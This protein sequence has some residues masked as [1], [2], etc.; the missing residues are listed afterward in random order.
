[1]SCQLDD[2]EIDRETLAD[3]ACFTELSETKL[4]VFHHY[5]P[6]NAAKATE[7]ASRWPSTAHLEKLAML[8][9][10]QLRGAKLA[11]AERRTHLSRAPKATAARAT[12][13]EI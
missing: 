7:S 13:I 3:T 12:H 6:P 10:S 11:A 2:P 4:D 9:E 5:L 1:V 8:R